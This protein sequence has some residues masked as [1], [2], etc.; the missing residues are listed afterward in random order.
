M[1]AF[2]KTDSSTIAEMSWVVHSIENDAAE[3]KKDAVMMAVG[4][5]SRGRLSMGFMKD[6][7]MFGRLEGFGHLAMSGRRD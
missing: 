4:P 2:Q 7:K 1:F 5:I 6:G 3:I